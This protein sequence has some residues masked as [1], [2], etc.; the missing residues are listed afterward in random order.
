MRICHIKR[1]A[2]F[3]RAFDQAQFWV[4]DLEPSQ[5]LHV[6]DSLAADFCGARAFGFQSL[7]IDRSDN[8]KVTQYQDWLDAPD[9]PGKTPSD[10]ESGTVPDLLAV[11]A[12]LSSS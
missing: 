3:Q 4:P 11:K 7:L 12:L 9:Y 2:V 5:V 1:L 10:V 8:A 6:G